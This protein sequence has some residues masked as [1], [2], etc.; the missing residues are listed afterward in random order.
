[1]SYTILEAELLLNTD[2]NNTD[3]FVQNNSDPG[4]EFTLNNTNPETY[5]AQKNTDHGLNI[6]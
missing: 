5:S 4:T 3:Y 1:M 2:P 6:S